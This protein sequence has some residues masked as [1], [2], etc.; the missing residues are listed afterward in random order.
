MWRELGAGC[1]QDGERG[2]LMRGLKLRD[3]FGIGRDEFAERRANGFACNC[4]KVARQQDVQWNRV[5]AKT[6]AEVFAS[7]R[8]LGPFFRRDYR[9]C[10]EL[11]IN[12]HHP[13]T[14]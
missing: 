7:A 4:V 9:A 14:A 6:A 13:R 3:L 8:E 1:V 11:T 5:V 10:T 2:G 12:A